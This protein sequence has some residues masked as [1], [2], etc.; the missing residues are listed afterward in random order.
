MITRRLWLKYTASMEVS[1]LSISLQPEWIKPYEKCFLLHHYDVV[2]VDVVASDVTSLQEPNPRP[3]AATSGANSCRSESG[4][5]IPRFVWFFSIDKVS[6]LLIRRDGVQLWVRHSKLKVGSK[7]NSDVTVVSL[8]EYLNYQFYCITI[9]LFKALNYIHC[10]QI[11]YNL[12]MLLET[13]AW[14]FLFG[15]RQNLTHLGVNN[16]DALLL[17]SFC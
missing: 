11:C 16:I 2:P 1:H 4:A 14:R 13:S 12:K 7:L 3:A 17:R 10:I 5:S 9:N 6:V 15:L 8:I